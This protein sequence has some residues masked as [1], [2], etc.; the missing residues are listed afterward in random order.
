M[1]LALQLRLALRLKRRGVHICVRPPG[2]SLAETFGRDGWCAGI[3]VDRSAMRHDLFPKRVGC[4]EKAPGSGCYRL[5]VS[6]I[7][8]KDIVLEYSVPTARC[9]PAAV[10][11]AGNERVLLTPRR[12]EISSRMDRKSHLAADNKCLACIHMRFDIRR[13]GHLRHR[14]PRRGPL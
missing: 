9:D 1:R 14:D 3:A 4:C 11:C 6:T 5:E 13:D 7:G 2:R 10:F 8:S 12:R